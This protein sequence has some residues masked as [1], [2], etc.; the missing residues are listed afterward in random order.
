MVQKRHDNSSAGVK[1]TIGYAAP[2]YGVGSKVSRTG[3]M[4]SYGIL[5]L[6]MMTH[7]KPTYLEFGEG[8]NLHSYTKKAMGD[9]ALEIV[10]PVLLK[11]V[12]MI[13]PRINEEETIG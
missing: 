11:D 4:Y 5:F 3:D 1:G 12:R 13:G 10:D 2:E 8:L 7:K 9:G 6:E